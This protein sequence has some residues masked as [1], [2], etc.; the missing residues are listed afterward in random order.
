MFMWNW[1][2]GCAVTA[3]LLMSGCAS[4]PLEQGRSNVRALVQSRTPAHL[5]DEAPSSAQVAD[6][7]LTEWL[8]VPLTLEH[9]QQI[10]LIRSPALQAHYARLG[11]S[12]ADVFEAGRLR[13]P[14]LGLSWLFPIGAAQGSKVGA[15]LTTPFADLLLRSSRRRIAAD[16][17][18][19][20]QE[21]IAAATLEV[22]A[23][24]Q[25]AWFE[26]VAAAQHVAV[27]RSISDASQLSA[28]LAQQYQDAGNITALDL[29]IQRA[30]ASQARIGLHDAQMQL[31]DARAALQKTLGLTDAHSGWTV[32]EVLPDVPPAIPATWQPRI[33]SALE[34]RLDIA[35]ARR[36][37]QTM[38]QRRDATGRYRAL[39]DSRVGASLDRESDGAKRVGPSIELALPLFQQGQGAV[40]RADSELAI[41]QA[42]LAELEGSAQAELSRHFSRLQLAHEQV[43]AYRD[44]LIPAREAIVAR[45]REQANYMLVDSFAV[46][47]AR[48]QEYAAYAGY[49]DAQLN[50]WNAQVQLLRATG[51]QRG[52]EESR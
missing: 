10:A 3:A 24:A 11:I 40:A 42:R 41:A 30:E 18:A 17:F 16:E 43:A 28:D 34:Q 4:L 37:V 33:A 38:T 45:T 9:A 2:T 44:T 35:A 15:S 26:C 6:A 5:A 50:F 32:P 51:S 47:M 36:N 27:S 46:L 39:A 20:L 49:V 8:A 12:A 14:V 21:E 31:A 1:R 7:R 29:Q 52:V 48:Q 22:M 25:R 13:N 19:G 23:D